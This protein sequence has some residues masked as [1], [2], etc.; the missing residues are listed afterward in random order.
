MQWL[1]SFPPRPF[2]GEGHKQVRMTP[3]ATSPKDFFSPSLQHALRATQRRLRRVDLLAAMLL[4]T[5]VGVLGILGSVAADHLVA[6]GLSAATRTALRWSWIALEA[7]LLLALVVLPLR[8]RI[9]DLYAARRMES[10]DPAL[11]NEITASLQLRGET[12]TAA[13][14]AAAVRRRA[15]QLA[16]GK[17]HGAPPPTRSLRAAGA[18][19]GAVILAG[20]FY[21]LFAPKSTL[22]SLRR[23]LGLGDPPAPT[24]TQILS[25]AP[26]DG[27]TV[28]AGEEVLFEARLRYPVEPVILQIAR[29]KQPVRD[30]DCLTLAPLDEPGP[31]EAYRG[32]WKAVGAGEAPT[33]FRLLGGDARTPWRRLRVLPRPALRRVGGRCDWPEYTGAAPRRSE[34]GCLEG[35]AGSRATV[36]AEAN[37]PVRQAVLVFPSD[38]RTIPMTPDASGRILTASFRID[39]TDRYVIRY[40]LRDVEAR[41]ESI[42]HNVVILP[43]RPPSVRRESPPDTVTASEKETLEILAHVEDDFGVGRLELVCT[44]GG[45]TTTHRLWRSAAPGAT[46]RHVRSE[47][48]VGDLGRPGETLTC[49]LRARDFSPVSAGGH[50]GQSEPFTLTIVSSST[51]AQ[52]PPQHDKEKQNIPEP[53]AAPDSEHSEAAAGEARKSSDESPSVPGPGNPPVANATPSSS[54]ESQVDTPIL[55]TEEARKLEQLCCAMAGRKTGDSSDNSSRQAVNPK[56]GEKRE[57]TPNTA[58]EEP[59]K[60][61]APAPERAGQGG[62]KAKGTGEGKGKNP[63]PAKKEMSSSDTEGQPDGDKANRSTRGAAEPQDRNFPGQGSGRRKGDLEAVVDETLLMPGTSQSLASVGRALREAQRQIEEGRPD[64]KLLEAT[65]MTPGE[66]KAFVEKLTPR[67]RQA[68]QQARRTPR[69]EPPV[70]FF[71]RP[72]EV[73]KGAAARTEN[74]FAEESAGESS[75]FTEDRR[76]APT[77]VS[78]EY[79]KVLE[80]YLRTVS[81]GET[82]APPLSP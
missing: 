52:Q 54:E 57:Q 78:P 5:A 32:V 56:P 51:A 18:A 42:P 80:A 63:G 43:D 72:T 65:E 23:V 39:K 8:R 58:T 30:E 21:W 62:E 60:E 20:M 22:T 77:F 38:G 59:G 70:P 36:T 33:T 16:Q 27:T 12:P 2:A 55:T 26:P 3:P 19:A 67:Y 64:P 28:L 34:D 45:H 71:D 81:E 1:F 82:N 74:V 46:R 24:R 4:L 69:T 9:S 14:T 76:A 44:N 68:L 31:G 7:F 15:E 17:P 11:H 66:F 75:R 35:P 48:P 73:R 29:G 13:A 41:A 37:L 49:L 61:Q 25:L 10:T 6:G 50:V 53:T 47:V 40:E 79:R